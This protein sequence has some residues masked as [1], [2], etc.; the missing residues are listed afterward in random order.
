[1]NVSGTRAWPVA[2]AIALAA[3]VTV[4]APVPVERIAG[5]RYAFVVLGEDGVAVLVRSLRR[6]IVRTSNSTASCDRWSARASGDDPAAADAQ[7]ARRIEAFG[8]SG[9]D[10]R[11]GGPCGRC[12]PRP[13]TGVLPPAQPQR[14]VVIGDTGCRIKTGDNLF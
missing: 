3:C 10:L 4:P 13:S 6:S 11:E 14:I 8:V 2:V 9:A 5:T 1:M 7:H 12:A